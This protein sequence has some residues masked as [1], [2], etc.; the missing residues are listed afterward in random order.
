M[1]RIDQ[2]KISRITHPSPSLRTR[3]VEQF[4]RVLA[5]RLKKSKAQQQD[6]Q[7]KQQKKKPRQQQW[8]LF[9]PFALVLVKAILPVAMV[10][11]VGAG[12]IGHMEG[13][14]TLDR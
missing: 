14:T 8:E 7:A 13:W 9:S 10:N 1:Y 3:Q 12:V 11:A 5:A 4:N 2:T 6:A